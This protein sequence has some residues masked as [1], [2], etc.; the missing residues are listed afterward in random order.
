M[1]R[2]AQ[3]AWT[4]YV[5]GKRSA[6]GEV[7]TLLHGPMTLFC[8]GIVHDEEVAKN[9]SSESL[10]KLLEQNPP[11][12]IE[13]VVN[14]LYTVCRNQCNSFWSTKKRR[15]EILEAIEGR[16]NTY[17]PA[18]GLWNLEREDYDKLLKNCLNDAEHHIWKLHLQGYSND[19]ICEELALAEK[20]VANKKT[21]A[22]QKLKEA[23][24]NEY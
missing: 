16:F 9:I 21:M 6:F 2:G 8:L 11:E 5:K 12:Q 4:K 22:R 18:E 13:N 19:E 3:E 24:N 20:T 10:L 1:I 23:F 15:K 14:W 7:Y 17:S